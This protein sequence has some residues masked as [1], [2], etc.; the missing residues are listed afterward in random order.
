MSRT[1]AAFGALVIGA[2]VHG[3]ATALE[4]ARRGVPRVALVERF[5]LHHPHGSSHG[6]GRITRTT[7]SDPRYVKLMQVAHREDWPR[8]EAESGSTLIH[9]AD[10]IFFGPADGEL[11]Q[12]AAAV[13]TAGAPGVERLTPAEA[14]VRV[15]AFEFPDAHAVLHDR[16]GGVVGAA[17]TLLALDRR[18]R[19]EGVHVLEETRVLGLEPTAD[20]IAVDTDRG[21][22]LAERVVVTAG[23]W[24][25]ELLPSLRERLR[26][27]R[28]SVGYFDFGDTA[29]AARPGRFPVWVY[30]GNA[31]TGLYY[32]LPEF[33]REGIKAALHGS[34]G[35]G[36]DPD[37][38]P[39]PDLLELA[40][41]RRFLE[42]QLVGTLGETLHAETCL[43]TN[44]PDEHFVIGP[45]PGAPRVLVGSICSGHGFKFGPLMGRIL[46]G[47]AIDGTSG[48][49]EFEAARSA[50]APPA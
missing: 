7:Y 44:T 31:D 43:Y 45:V 35:G 10:G 28:Q 19:I 14:R 26:V 27:K 41:T 39:G 16:T 20:P 29:E 22:L 49:P 30:L 6:D 47:L 8:L 33:G 37:R 1:P 15:P 48:V 18:C 32:G 9:R 13:E 21:R 24:V 3:L 12:W 25:G 36:D 38:D 34:G 11:E 17:D 40:S 5:R 46:A 4:L 23:A 42:W 2:G 50:F